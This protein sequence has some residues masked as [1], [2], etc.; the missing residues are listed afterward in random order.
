MILERNVHKNSSRFLQKISLKEFGFSF[1]PLLL[2]S[3]CTMKYISKKITCQIIMIV[4][5]IF[6][7]LD[8]Q[9][10]QKSTPQMKCNS[11]KKL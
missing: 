6:N 10:L 8:L 2:S 9:Y 7:Y 11:A 4:P 5:I 1:I 3:L